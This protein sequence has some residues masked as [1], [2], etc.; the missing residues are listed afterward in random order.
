MKSLSIGHRRFQTACVV[1]KFGADHDV[2]AYLDHRRERAA[3]EW[4]KL[5]IRWRIESPSM[6]RREAIPATV[7]DEVWKRDGECCS[8]CGS[9]ERLEF[10]HIIP[11]SMGGIKH[12]LEH[13]ASVSAL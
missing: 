1:V 10:D 7:R 13:R 2:E 6:Y 9:Q 8:K 12:G 11:V 4:K 5:K 3:L